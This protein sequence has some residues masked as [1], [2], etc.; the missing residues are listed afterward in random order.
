VK[1]HSDCTVAE[2]LFCHHIGSKIP[3]Q[4]TLDEVRQSVK[5]KANTLILEQ[6]GQDA[7]SEHRPVT[8]VCL[9]PQSAF[10]K[11]TFPFAEEEAYAPGGGH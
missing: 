8:A 1:V 9:Y 4:P 2:K 5:Y 3:C 7:Q 6:Y 11:R 10:T